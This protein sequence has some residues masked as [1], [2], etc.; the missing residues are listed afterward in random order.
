MDPTL[1]VTIEPD[2]SADEAINEERGNR[3]ALL[4]KNLFGSANDIKLISDTV[5]Q[6]GSNSVCLL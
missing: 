5:P 6:E 3:D 2:V 1:E 4:L